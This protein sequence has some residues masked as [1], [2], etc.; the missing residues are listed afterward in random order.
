MHKI[1]LKKSKRKTAENH[2]RKLMI[3]QE[4]LLCGILGLLCIHIC[5]VNVNLQLLEILILVL[6]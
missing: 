6:E 5:A 2:I 4:M 1:F 3:C